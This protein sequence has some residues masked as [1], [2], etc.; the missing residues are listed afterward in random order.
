MDHL[1]H[2]PDSAPLSGMR[3][4]APHIKPVLLAG[5][6]FL[7]FAA[8]APQA[9]AQR[10]TF[11]YSGK[12]ATYKVRTTALYQI[13]AYG[14]QGGNAVFPLTTG[15]GGLGAEIGG[16]FALSAGTRLQIAVGGAGSDENGTGGG[17]GGGTFVV[18]PDNTPLVI[19]GGGGG[20]GAIGD[21][22]T[23]PFPGGN[24]L[25]SQNGGPSPPASKGNG[26][27][28]GNGGGGGTGVS[29]GAGGGGFL[30]PGSNAIDVTGE[31]T[32]TGGGAF[33]SLTG[34]TKGGGFG[35][36]GGAGQDGAGGGGGY[37]GGSGGSGALGGTG[38]A[39]GGGSFDGGIN[40]V[41]LA[42]TQSG[43]GE[44]VIKAIFVG[45]PGKPKC[46][47][48]VVSNLTKRYH[49]LDDAAEALG[50]SSVPLMQ[51]DITTYCAGA[52]G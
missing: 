52:I 37:S 39:G 48:E 5:A 13:T 2:E 36:G 23:I 21:P 44:V 42:G 24:G 41:L 12:L 3:L 43:D 49:G 14:A 47:G 4:S 16:D 22:R 7:A 51:S 18:G 6:A 20:G 1:Q 30:S 27:T 8:F 40:P 46:H 17:G 11:S 15:P 33:L 10:A 29:P 19:A 25:T 34:G 50:Y 32:A 38:A 9:Q 26:G 35:G 31:L 45:T 28:G